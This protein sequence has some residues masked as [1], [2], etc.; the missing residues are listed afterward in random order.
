MLE[1]GWRGGVTGKEALTRFSTCV[2]RVLPRNL[3]MI[4]FCS[5]REDESDGQRLGSADL[6]RTSS[7]SQRDTRR[8]VGG[9]AAS[10]LGFW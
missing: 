8:H 6:G 7:S 10:N 5:H 2:I 1:G 4:R 3:A 9:H